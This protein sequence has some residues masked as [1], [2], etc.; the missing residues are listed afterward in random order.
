MSA[1]VK[2]TVCWFSRDR[3][4]GFCLVDGDEA[5]TEYFLHYSSIDMEG[6]KMLKPKQ[7][8]TFV[9]KSTDKGIQATEVIPE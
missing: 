2:G 9:L 1:R 6:Y 8:V 7:A 3:G 4:F 5:K